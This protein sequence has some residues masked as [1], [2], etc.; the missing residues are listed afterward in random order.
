MK[1]RTFYCALGA[2][3]GLLAAK[4]DVIEGVA[5]VLCALVV[6]LLTEPLVSR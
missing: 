5:L 6:A 4:G 2:W 1:V 3:G